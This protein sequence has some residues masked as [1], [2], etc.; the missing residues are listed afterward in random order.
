MNGQPPRGFWATSG[1]LAGQLAGDNPE[2]SA[3]KMSDAMVVVLAACLVT[4]MVASVLACLAFMFYRKRA[5]EH[6]LQMQRQAELE[7][8]KS[9]SHDPRRDA[10]GGSTGSRDGSQ[11]GSAGGSGPSALT[12]G[13]RR[14]RGILQGLLRDSMPVHDSSDSYTVPEVVDRVA[15]TAELARSKF[16]PRNLAAQD[17]EGSSDSSNGS[18]GVRRGRSYG[19]GLLQPPATAAG[20]VSTTSMASDACLARLQSAISVMSQDVLSRRLQYAAGGADGSPVYPAGGQQGGV[21]RR[22]PLVLGQTQQPQQQQQL[23]LTPPLEAAGEEQ[24]QRQASGSLLARSS[25]SSLARSSMHAAGSPSALVAIDQQ[26][27]QRDGWDPGVEAVETPGQQQQRATGAGGGVKT[28]LLTAGGALTA[29]GAGGGLA[30]SSYGSS[31]A[32]R[33]G[34]SGGLEQLKLLQLVGQGT[35]GQVY[36]ALWRRRCVAVKVLQLPATAGSSDVPWKGMGRTTS[37]REKMAVMETVVSTTM[38]WAWV[39]AGVAAMLCRPPV[40]GYC[41]SSRYKRPVVVMLIATC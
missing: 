36:K 18:D 38:R 10:M 33:I 35:F 26:Q 27:Q 30:K 34:C 28:T 3:P 13:A 32:S 41:S 2:T 39:L 1:Q 22:S 25:S 20:G 21:A 8:G 37:H 17:G 7:E 4:A 9:G 24:L 6:R 5:A 16:G 12:P 14:S 19:A 11:G 29:A 31:Q 23:W 15:L 40:V